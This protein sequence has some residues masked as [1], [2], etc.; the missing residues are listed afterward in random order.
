MA[1][2]ALVTFQNAEDR[3]P[4]PGLRHPGAGVSPRRLLPPSPSLLCFPLCILGPEVHLE[5]PSSFLAEG[6]CWNGGE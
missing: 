3:E 6:L 1:W 2:Q 4:L 5:F